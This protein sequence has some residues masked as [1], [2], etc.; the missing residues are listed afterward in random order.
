MRATRHFHLI[1]LIFLKLFGGSR[2]SIVSIAIRYKL[3]GPAFESQQ[4]Q[5]VFI[6]PISR[7]AISP[8]NVALIPFDHLTR[9]LDQKSF[10]GEILCSPKPSGRALPSPT[11]QVPSFFFLQRGKAAE[12]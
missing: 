3:R 4:G 12:A 11:Q 9:L 1:D 10:I 2:A 6:S 8:R 7:K 5:D